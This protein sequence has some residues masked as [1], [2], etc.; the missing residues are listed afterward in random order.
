MLFASKVAAALV[1]PLNLSILLGLLALG[2]A[3]RRSGRLAAAS[4]ALALLVLVVPSLPAVSDA[5]VASL[6]RGYPPA[7]PAEAP[8]AD[9][10]VVLGGSLAT[11]LPPRRGPELVD[12][13][14]RVLHAARLH[15]AGKAPLV[16]AT[17]GRLPWSA[18][19]RSDAA[20]M[21][22]LLVE[23]GVPREAILLEER[24][25]TTAENAAETARLLRP[26]RARRVLLV[27]SS[28]HMRRALE[29]FRAEGLEVVPSACDALV[30]GPP[31]AG[32]FAFLPAPA[33]LARTHRALKELLGLAFY[34]V[35]GRA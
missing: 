18:A 13:S 29:A 27:T 26:R 24:S 32:V 2:F 15:R 17:G 20:E 1:F 19:K 25:R 4:G 14:D 11:G 10:V 21:T 16:V 3:R 8:E 5:L 7:D 6:E 31:V 23:W 22:E 34:R 35:T 9:A 33:A 28:L 30:A 12:A